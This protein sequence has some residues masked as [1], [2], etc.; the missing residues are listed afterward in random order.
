MTGKVEGKGHQLAVRH[1]YASPPLE[2]GVNAHL[3]PSAED[4]ARAAVTGRPVNAAPLPMCYAA[5]DVDHR[6]RTARRRPGAREGVG[7]TAGGSR[8]QYPGWHLHTI[9]V[10]EPPYVAP[11][12]EP[13]H[14]PFDLT[15]GGAPGTGF[16]A[17]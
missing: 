12:T 2:D 9:G 3:M 11:R 15:A 13:L 1:R 14:W 10:G 17:A 8:R 16:T 5:S 7:N 4:R 6:P